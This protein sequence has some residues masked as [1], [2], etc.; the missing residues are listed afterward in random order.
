M[1]ENYYFVI[2]NDERQ[3]QSHLCLKKK[4]RPPSVTAKILNNKHL[5]LQNHGSLIHFL[6]QYFD[7]S[8]ECSLSIFSNS[9]FEYLTENN[10]ETFFKTLSHFQIHLSVP[11][12]LSVIFKSESRF[13][14]NNRSSS[15]SI[16][17]TIPSLSISIYISQMQNEIEALRHPSKI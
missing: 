15:K 10:L 8:N 1:K 12:S 16:D 17:N 7:V 3:T 6:L 13:V 9:C 11:Q 2:K 14:N 5:R 4:S